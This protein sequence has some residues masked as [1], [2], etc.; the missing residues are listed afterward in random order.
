[1]LIN[2]YTEKKIHYLVEME[3]ALKNSPYVFGFINI[4]HIPYSKLNELFSDQIDKERFLFDDSRGYMIEESLYNNYK[5]FFDKEIHFTFDFNLFE[6][7][8]R[9]SSATKDKTY[10]HEVLPPLFDKEH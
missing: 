3:V 8:V 7:S 9:L 10:Y 2:P 4:S 6:Y 5:D 1:M